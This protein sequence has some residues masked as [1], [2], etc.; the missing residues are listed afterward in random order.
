MAA[1]SSFFP[2]SSPT[3]AVSSLPISS[4]KAFSLLGLFR[5][6]T[7]TC[8]DK[9]YPLSYHKYRKKFDIWNVSKR[10]DHFSQKRLW[11]GRSRG[12]DCSAFVLL[13]QAVAQRHSFLCKCLSCQYEASYLEV[14]SYLKNSALWVWSCLPVKLALV[15][16]PI[17]PSVPAQ[18]RL[19]WWERGAALWQL[20]FRLMQM[21]T[22]FNRCHL[23]R[24]QWMWPSFSLNTLLMRNGQHHKV[25]RIHLVHDGLP[26][27]E[28]YCLVP[29][30]KWTSVSQRNTF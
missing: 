30:C 11:P 29:D 9:C 7:A 4:V 15:R 24:L 22:L 21:W 16:S 26:L 2:S 18:S 23:A 14:L 28:M 8:I 20:L 13:C 12:D 17:Y 25:Q 27:Y 19:S 5:V 10:P 6:I 1:L 3:L